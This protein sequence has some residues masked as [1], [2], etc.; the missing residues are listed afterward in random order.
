[1]A[2]IPMFLSLVRELLS[3]FERIA[4]ITINFVHINSILTRNEKIRSIATHLHDL[5]RQ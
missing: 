4:L 3:A 1:M 2:A 5:T